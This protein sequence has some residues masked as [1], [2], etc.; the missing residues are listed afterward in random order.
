MPGILVEIVGNASQFKKELE[1]S[2]A[3]TE[4]A[5]TG[6]S[7]MSK[8][9]GIAG[10][11]LAGGLAV[12][13]DKSIHAAE[14]MQVQNARLAQAFKSSGVSLDAYKGS[15]DE[16]EGSARKLGFTN[17]DVRNSLGSLI[18]ATHDGKKAISDLAVAQ[19][20]ARFKNVDLGSAT[21][22]LT[23]AMSG[24]QRAVKQLGLSIQP[25]TNAY[26]TLK[27]TMH[28]HLTMQEKEELAAAKAIDKQ[29]TAAEVID[30]VSRKLGGQ[31]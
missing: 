15:I 20:I 22:M 9:A 6:F 7:K 27:A 10:L 21:K 5:N 8:V 12:G 23:M 19:N 14:E 26:D 1:S 4:K 31:A 16:A 17:V 2:V 29:K 24:S 25:V 18:I 3:A 28:G 13:L 30:V 11:A